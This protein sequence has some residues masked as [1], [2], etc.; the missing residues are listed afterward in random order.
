LRSPSA[1]PASSLT[2]P[3]NCL[4][5]PAMRSLS[6]DVF[7]R[8]AMM[9]RCSAARPRLAVLGTG[10]VPDLSKDPCAESG[11]RNSKRIASPGRCVRR[12]ARRE[13]RARCR[14]WL[15]CHRT[16]TTWSGW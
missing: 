15:R 12:A 9:E 1:L 8:A 7:S 14:G 6:M 5:D 13:T 2:P 11:M 4:M 10:L 3:T 16:G